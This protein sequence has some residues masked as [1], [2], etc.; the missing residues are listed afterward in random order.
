MS[1]RDDGLNVDDLQLLVTY[2]M[3]Y[4]NYLNW[5]ARQ[6]FR[7]ANWASFWL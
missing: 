4:G 1:S 5:F 3:P 7:P 2:T 6:A